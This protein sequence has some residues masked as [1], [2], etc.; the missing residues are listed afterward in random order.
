M[1][2]VITL[3]FKGG[4]MKKKDE[5]EIDIPEIVCVDPEELRKAILRSRKREKRK[6]TLRKIFRR[7]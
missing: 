5:E 7:K 3:T 4:R 1:L 6:E 2:I